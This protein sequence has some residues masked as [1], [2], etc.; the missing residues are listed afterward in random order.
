MSTSSPICTPASRIAMACSN[1]LS[2]SVARYGVLVMMM[3]Y[4]P[5]VRSLTSSPVASLKV[6]TSIVSLCMSRSS[7]VMFITR[8]SV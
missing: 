6:F 2:S 3:S 8:G 1:W 7:C 4:S 5:R